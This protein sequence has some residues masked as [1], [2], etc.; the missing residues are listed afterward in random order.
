MVRIID[1]KLHFHVEVFE[2][3]V[4]G[5]C[6]TVLFVAL[7][8]DDLKYILEELANKAGSSYQIIL[9]T[10]PHNTSL[11]FQMLDNGPFGVHKRWCRKLRD[12]V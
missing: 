4:T 10:F 2:S 3:F 6:L 11:V 1:F 9:L 5:A 8:N 12:H 7:S